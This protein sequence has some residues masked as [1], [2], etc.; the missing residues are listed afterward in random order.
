MKKLWKVL[1]GIFIT[2][3]VLFILLIAV[4]LINGQI[5][6]GK[7]KIRE[8]TLEANSA[9]REINQEEPEK[10]N[11]TGVEISAVKGDYL[12][13]YHLIPEK[14]THRG[15]V[16][17][18]GGSE[19]SSN[20]NMAVK[21]AKEGYEVYSLY[22][23]GRDNQQKELVKVP[24]EF[25]TE[26]YAEIEKNAVSAR[27]LTILGGSK[28]AEL[29]LLLSGKYPE[30]VDNVVLYAPSNYVFQGLSY[31]YSSVNS[32]WS[33]QGK[34]LDYLHLTA[35][36]GSTYSMFML[37]MFLNA[38]IEYEP[39][40]RSVTENAENKE[41][42]QIDV[43]KAKANLLIFAGK[44]DKM[45]PSADMA[46]DIIK[47]YPAEKKLVVYEKAGHIFFGPPVL[48]N[49]SVGGEYDANEAAK[50]DS[51]QILLKTLEEWTKNK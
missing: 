34:E 45:W 51:D 11:L 25:F 32:S 2:I 42:A 18:F 46:E 41:A 9:Y 1:K 22:F 16:I 28:G 47:R 14:I 3:A 37:R 21:L 40:Y 31:D 43:S 35:A 8:S 33:F 20:I 24:L 44:E 15:T 10:S 48:S 50:V 29:C 4:R 38:P 27:P 19:G 36:S 17:T 12:N 26:A 23:F 6:K 13:G 30:L 5:T 49:M 7:E 39:I